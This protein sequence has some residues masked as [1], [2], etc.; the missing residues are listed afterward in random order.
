[1]TTRHGK[2]VTNGDDW[3][4]LYVDGELVEQGH[5]V[6][7][8]SFMGL[9]SYETIDVDQEWADSVGHYPEFFSDIPAEAFYDPRSDD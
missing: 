9:D 4:G 2:L 7:R 6:S 8:D 3:E 1:M 5:T